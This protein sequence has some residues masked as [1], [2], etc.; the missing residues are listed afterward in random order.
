VTAGL[1]IGFC[2]IDQ[3]GESPRARG[4]RRFSGRASCAATRVTDPI[5]S[6]TLTEMCYLIVFQIVA[7]ICAYGTRVS[8]AASEP[9]QRIGAHW[10]GATRYGTRM[11]DKRQGYFAPLTAFRVSAI[12][13]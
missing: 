8:L 10:G 1:A 2:A 11:T 5:I 13:I 6:Q 4:Q 7:S 9:R 3:P 12:D